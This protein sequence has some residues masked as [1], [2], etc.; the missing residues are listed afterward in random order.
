MTIDEYIFNDIVAD[1]G[2]K[3]FTIGRS[4]KIYWYITPMPKSG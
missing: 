1:D 3:G 4:K 2:V